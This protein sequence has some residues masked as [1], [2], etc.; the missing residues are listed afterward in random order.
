MAD[1]RGESRANAEFAAMNAANQSQFA[2]RQLTTQIDTLNRQREADKRKA[3][4]LLFRS[5]RS[6]GG[7]FFGSNPGGALG[8]TGVLG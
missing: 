7:G 5:L 3:D 2:Q 8:G 6:A 1:R 4:R